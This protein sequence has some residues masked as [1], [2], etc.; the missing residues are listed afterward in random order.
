MCEMMMPSSDDTLTD[1]EVARSRYPSLSC[2]PTEPTM[3]A[4]DLQ[5]AR[6][7]LRQ[8][9][10]KMVCFNGPRLRSGEVMA[11]VPRAGC[12]CETCELHAE[13]EAEERK[14]RGE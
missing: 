11:R 9:S 7:L 13:I 12:G 3:L 8:A 2:G 10:R 4:R 14:W 6:E 1:E 5:R